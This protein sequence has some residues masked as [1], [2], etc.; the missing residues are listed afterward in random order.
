[1]NDASAVL[2]W[3]VIRQD[4]NGNRYRV[5]GYATEGEARRMVDRL[6]EKGRDQLYKVERVGTTQ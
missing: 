5:G 3:L 2:P 1:M 6:D 4:A